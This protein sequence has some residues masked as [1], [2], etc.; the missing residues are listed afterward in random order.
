MK[1]SQVSIKLNQN[2]KKYR[3][4]T[5]CYLHHISFTGH[6]NSG[7]LAKFMAEVLTNEDWFALLRDID[8]LETDCATGSLATYHIDIPFIV[9][10]ESFS[11]A[12][13]EYYKMKAIIYEG[14]DP[15]KGPFTTFMSKYMKTAQWLKFLLH[16]NQQ[17]KLCK[18]KLGDQVTPITYVILFYSVKI[19]N[20]FEGVLRK[21][22]ISEF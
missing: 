16:Y 10:L 21:N 14:S 13:S 6:D 7:E 1:F 19:T 20:F 2:S 5:I 17:S 22:S 9:G 15:L 8:G 18:E 4:G 11:K 3:L 12:E